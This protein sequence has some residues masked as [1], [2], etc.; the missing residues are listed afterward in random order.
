MIETAI[1]GAG[2]AGAY[3]ADCLT[4]KGIYPTLFDHS[5]PREKPCGGLIS[6]LTQEVFPFVKQI[7]VEHLKIDKIHI[8]SPSEKQINLNLKKSFLS[9]SRLL[10]DK[11]L[12]DHAIEKGAEFIDEKVIDLN[13]KGDFWYLKTQKKTYMAKILI[14]ADG[15]TSLVR[16]KIIGPLP[17]NDIGLCF[18]YFAY[19]SKVKDISM[20]FSAYRNGY[21]WVIPRGFNTCFG[22]GSAKIS[23]TFNLKNELDLFMKKNFPLIKK[24]SKWAALIPS[25]KN[26]K[27]FVKPLAGKNWILI[28][29]AAGHV[30][31]MSGEGILYA[32]VDGELA[33]Q[34]ISEDS[35]E[36]FNKLWMKNFKINLFLEIEMG[37]WLYKKPLL[38]LYC[39]SYKLRL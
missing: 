22:I 11:Y 35:P 30:N 1:I 16:E 25:I 36:K 23:G 24:I 10:F 34:A 39:Q 27:I 17:R 29:D 5:H 31:P 8:I 18:G 19:D 15:V 21:I 14:G 26:S 7:P 9:F 37:K 12:V 3:C 20:V 13:R 2:P 32:L 33:A 28:G 4:K 6:P 38:E